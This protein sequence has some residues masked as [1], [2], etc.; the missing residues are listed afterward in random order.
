MLTPPLIVGSTNCRSH[1]M[2]KRVNSVASLL[3]PGL[4]L[5]TSWKLGSIKG[6]GGIIKV[7]SELVAA[8]RGS[9]FAKLRQ[10][11]PKLSISLSGWV[12]SSCCGGGGMTFGRGMPCSNSLFG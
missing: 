6:S 11:L 12:S 8:L 9:K 3:T 5:L 1:E 7:G 10:T 2:P 4:P